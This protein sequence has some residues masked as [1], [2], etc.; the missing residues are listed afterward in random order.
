R[1]LELA[2]EARARRLDARATRRLLRQVVQPLVPGR[3]GAP[4]VRSRGGRGLSSY[5]DPVVP[6][7]MCEDFLRIR[8]LLDRAHASIPMRGRRNSAAYETHWYLSHPYFPRVFGCV[9]AIALEEGVELRSPLY[10]RR[11]IDFAVRRPRPRR[12]E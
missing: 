4:L 12:L 3:A 9:A 1:W 7:W 6:G 2:R 5:L 10:D 11:I 8:G